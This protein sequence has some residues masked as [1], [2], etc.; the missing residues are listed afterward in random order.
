MSLKVEVAGFGIC[1]TPTPYTIFIVHVHQERFEAWTVYRQYESFV[2]LREQLLSLNPST[3]ELPYLDQND[4]DLNHLDSCRSILDL[5]LR[6]ATSNNY[7]LRM[8]F[9]YHFLCLD[10]NLPPP[11]LESHMRNY[12]SGSSDEMDM[13]DMFGDRNGDEDDDDA[14]MNDDSD[15]DSEDFDNDDNQEC[16]E[17]KQ[18]APSTV[19][20]MDEVNARCQVDVSHHSAMKKGKRDGRPP[21]GKHSRGAR[22][23]FESA[24]DREAGMDIKSLSY[25]E[26]EFI[27]DKADDIVPEIDAGARKRTINLDA[28]NIIRVI[29]QGMKSILIIFLPEFFFFLNF[30]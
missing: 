11:F 19:F 3:A 5:W 22:N 16:D 8:Q 15:D 14:D 1:R 23:D 26:A 25:V 18:S 20:M 10:A 7:I 9:M 27:Y 21:S 28:F 17:N 2:L 4:F 6:S 30:L 24:A 12:T 29:G 13:D